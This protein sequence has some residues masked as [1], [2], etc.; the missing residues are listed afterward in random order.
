[1]RWQLCEGELLGTGEA[2]LHE[3]KH[4]N[5]VLT[6]QLL[7]LSLAARLFGL[8]ASSWPLL[9]RG[10]R[11]I[12]HKMRQRSAF[13]LSFLAILCT[14]CAAAE[15]AD[16]DL[17]L[18]Y[19]RALP[20]TTK[21]YVWPT[22]LRVFEIVGRDDLTSVSAVVADYARS[23][24]EMTFWSFPGPPLISIYAYDGETTDPWQEFVV[25]SKLP[26]SFKRSLSAYDLD[27]QACAIAS[28]VDRDTWASGGVVFLD[29]SRLLGEEEQRECVN[30]GLDYI[31]GFPTTPRFDYRQFPS[32]EVRQLVLGAVM[33]CS[34]DG[35]VVGEP[36][37]L[38]KDGLTP[39]PSLD[40]VLENIDE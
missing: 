26:E 31:N 30:A 13:L 38:T 11:A 4:S 36:L 32:T 9:S 5:D 29:R 15:P 33:K 10:H 6:K 25:V 1:M 21:V 22:K 17:A 14:Y 34:R 20:S 37:E 8:L 27:S 24:P 39:L 28:L 16:R 18:A 7:L 35:P 12:S 2:I 23:Y 3:I 40:C 19:V